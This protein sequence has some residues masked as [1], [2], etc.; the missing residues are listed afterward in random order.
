MKL[1][2]FRMERMQSVWENQVR[3]NLSES[4][5]HPMRVA[6]L[7]TD[8]GDVLLGYPQSTGPAALRE[9]ITGLYPGSSADQ[10]IVATGTAEA[11]YISMWSLVEPGDQV[12]MLLPNYMQSWGIAKTLGAEIVPVWLSPTDGR[13]APDLAELESAVTRGTKFVAVCNPNNP[14][15]AVLTEAEMNTIGKIADKVGAW[16]IA[17]EVYRGAEVSGVTSP[18]FHGRYER[19][20]VTSGLSKAYGLPGLR[21]G[22]VVGPQDKI[23]D[24]WSYKDYTTI[25]IGAVSVRLAQAALEPT[26]HGRILERTRSVIRK[27]LP[28]IEKWAHRQE[29]F[30]LISPLA[31]AIVYMKYDLNIGS[32]DL[33]DR[34]REEKSV[35]IVPGEH[36]DMGHFVRIGFGGPVEELEKG[37]SLF[38]ELLSQIR[39]EVGTPG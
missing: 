39:S 24:L 21:V 1:E 3:Y 33:I 27:Q 7:D 34:L 36:F 19:T 4:G 17:D 26:R 20:L 38:G 11:N 29:V 5:V 16:V 23:A 2:P 22:W 14:T 18:T 37:L 25:G 15:G 28:I 9:L 32:L 35:L 12:V 30:E 8:V 31:G 10:V 6:D 13:W